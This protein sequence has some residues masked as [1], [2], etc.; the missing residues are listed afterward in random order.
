MQMKKKIKQ[1]LLLSV[2]AILFVLATVNTYKWIVSGE[3]RIKI[4]TASK[5]YTNSDLYLSIVAQENGV[6]LETE[7]KVKLLDSDG[8]KVKDAVVSYENSNVKISVPDLEP[9]NYFIEAKVSSEAG[10]DTIKKEI[11]IS[12]GNQENVTITFDKGIY[13]PRR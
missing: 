13:K 5:A 9:G 6:E 11:Y 12:N 4:S 8:K 10:K 7:S 1:I 2:F 3:Q